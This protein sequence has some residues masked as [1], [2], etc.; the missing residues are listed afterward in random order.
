MKRILAILLIGLMALPVTSLADS[1]LGAELGSIDSLKPSVYQLKRRA[2]PTALRS[3]ER[4]EN[5]KDA[6]LALASDNFKAVTWAEPGVELSARLT[7]LREAVYIRLGEWRGEGV[8]AFL[9]HELQSQELS[10]SNE[11]ALL[12]GLG[13]LE[14]SLESQEVLR[15]R[16]SAATRNPQAR[17]D[18]LQTL[19]MQGGMVAQRAFFTECESGKLPALQ[20]TKL[21][22]TLLNTTVV[23]GSESVDVMTKLVKQAALVPQATYAAEALWVT[24]TKLPKLE[25]NALWQILGTHGSE[26]L[27]ASLNRRLRWAE[28]RAQSATR[29]P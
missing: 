27:R 1:K 5:K 23:D 24:F 21:G 29:R 9:M 28:R 11:R 4:F 14:L 6:L 18:T 12:K 7:A 26:E 17:F 25:Q 13:K 15:A 8:E 2:E 22:A 20:L 10:D 16:V 3:L 19:M